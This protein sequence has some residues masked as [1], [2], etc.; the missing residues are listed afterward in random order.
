M[1]GG[2]G[3]VARVLLSVSDSCGFVAIQVF[4]FGCGLMVWLGAL[5]GLILW[6]LRVGF[7]A[8]LGYFVVDGFG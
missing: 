2:G 8:R 3:W 5:Q 6:V 7:P 4:V 1:T